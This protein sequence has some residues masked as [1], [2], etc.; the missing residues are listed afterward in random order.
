MSLWRVKLFPDST[1][2]IFF[3]V[4]LRWD[5]RCAANWQPLPRY[6]VSRIDRI[7]GDSGLIFKP[8]FSS[9]L[10]P[11]CQFGSLPLTK[12]VHFSFSRWHHWEGGLISGNAALIVSASFKS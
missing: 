12:K 2:D 9:Y 1:P 5:R 7:G 10:R 11:V 4:T 3:Y 6:S 8:F